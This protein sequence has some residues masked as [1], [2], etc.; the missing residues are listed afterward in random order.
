MIPAIPFVQLRWIERSIPLSDDI[1][2]IIKVLQSRYLLD[3]EKH[4]PFAEN[5]W[6]EWEDVPTV[7]EDE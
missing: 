5:R 7:E 1:S 2:R 4:S 6:S 3:P